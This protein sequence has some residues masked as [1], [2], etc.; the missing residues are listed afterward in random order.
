MVGRSGS[1]VEVL[2][3]DVVDVVDAVVVLSVPEEALSGV[4]RFIVGRS[5]SSAGAEPVSA[6]VPD[7][8][9]DL[10]EPDV[11]E[12]DVSEPRRFMVGRSGSPLDVLVVLVVVSGLLV[13]LSVGG[14]VSGLL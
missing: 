11:S 6:G 8:V 9:V 13:V 5:G 14:V 10:P 3:V 2:P 4:R 1:S 7:A 12:P